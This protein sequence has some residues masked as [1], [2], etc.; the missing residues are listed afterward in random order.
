MACG[1]INIIMQRNNL[2]KKKTLINGRIMRL[3]LTF[4]SYEY[5]YKRK[6]NMLKVAKDLLKGNYFS[7]KYS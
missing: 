4:R 1:I 5:E 6:I 7:A 2:K 3:Q